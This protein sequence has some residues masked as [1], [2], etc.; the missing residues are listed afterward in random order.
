MITQ[1]RNDLLQKVDDLNGEVKNLNAKLRN[2]QSLPSPEGN[3][4]QSSQVVVSQAEKFP[5][6]NEQGVE[7][8]GDD[9]ENGED[10][11][12]RNSFEQELEN[13]EI[14][15]FD[16]QNDLTGPTPNEDVFEGGKVTSRHIQP[17][18]EKARNHISGE[19]G[20]SA[21]KKNTLKQHIKAGHEKIKNHVCKEC[22]Y[23]ASL[24]STLKRHIA[25]VHENIKNH[26][27]GECGYATSLKH[28]LKA[29][30]EVVHKNNK[31]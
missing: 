1:E 2:I 12:D 19:C 13:S 18:H 20:Y 25:A 17:V 22:G 16:D 5:A 10:N 24:Q 30:I 3:P 23:A 27:C 26:L 15:P 7:S 4:H 8:S 31:R 29:H 14:T 6:T 11:V 21:P 28:R 9:N